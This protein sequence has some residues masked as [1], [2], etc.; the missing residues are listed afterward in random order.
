MVHHI[1][2]GNLP[3]D[4]VLVDLVNETPPDRDKL[5]IIA[6]GWYAASL[7]PFLDAFGDGTGSV[8][9]RSSPPIASPSARAS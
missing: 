3:G 8:R 6:G 2:M 5:G 1:E 7:R 4:S 9:R